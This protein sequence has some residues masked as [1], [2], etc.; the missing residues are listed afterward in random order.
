MVRARRDGDGGARGNRHTVGKC[1]RAQR[2][3]AHGNWREAEGGSVSGARGSD[4][5]IQRT[6][7][8]TIKPLGLS[9]EAVYPVHLVQPGF[10]PAL[11]PD[12]SVDLFAE[13]FE[14][15]RIGKE[16]IQDLCDS[17]LAQ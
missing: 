15:F 9:E 8:E 13:G 17:L 2:E 1:E 10:R 5:G 3:T 6:D 11:F 16:A 7:G 4:E 12:N 14:V